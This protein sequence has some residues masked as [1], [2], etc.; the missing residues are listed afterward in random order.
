[1]IQACAAVPSRELT[2]TASASSDDG[3]LF[4]LLLMRSTQLALMKPRTSTTGMLGFREVW[5]RLC[6]RVVW[7]LRSRSLAFC[8]LI[9]M[10]YIER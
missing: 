4:V 8:I 5:V 7:S 10:G 2:S 3:S 9:I 1:M 6:V